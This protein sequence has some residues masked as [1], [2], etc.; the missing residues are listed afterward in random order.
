[1]EAR[2]VGQPPSA[3][4]AD[5]STGRRSHILSHA[6]VLIVPLGD[7]APVF[8]A[9]DCHCQSSS[10]KAISGGATWRNRCT[11]CALLCRKW[12]IQ[13]FVSSRSIPAVGLA[14]RILPVRVARGLLAMRRRLT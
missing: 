4:Q 14:L 8:M 7:S 3:V 9:A 11:N 1:M 13:A 5:D 6:S 2:A 10:F 12:A